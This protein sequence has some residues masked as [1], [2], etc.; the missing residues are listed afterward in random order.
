M[1]RPSLLQRV[2]D[3]FRRAGGGSRQRVIRF[4]SGPLEP[5]GATFRKERMQFEDEAEGPQTVDIVETSTCAFG[6]TIDDKVRAAGVCA[7][8]DEV[9]CSTPGCLHQCCVCGAVVC[10]RHSRTYGDRTYCVRHRRV[11]YWRAFW[12]LE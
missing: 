10:R 5:G 11:H 4:I 7:I 3:H 8:G 9:L 1:N 12:G 2:L 6:H